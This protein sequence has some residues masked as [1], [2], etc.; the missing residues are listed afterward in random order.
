MGKALKYNFAFCTVADAGEKENFW[1][2]L[3]MNQK[4]EIF[5]SGSGI[6]VTHTKVTVAT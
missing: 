5:Y 1:F 6:S 4:F 3:K 2:S